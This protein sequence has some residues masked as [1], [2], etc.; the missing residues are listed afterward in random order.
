MAQNEEFWVVQG[1]VAA[2]G[3]IPEQY[4]QAVMAKLC[5]CMNMIG[6]CQSGGRT[7]VTGLRTKQLK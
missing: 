1:A 7:C 6:C 5:T 2:N 3:I 4:C